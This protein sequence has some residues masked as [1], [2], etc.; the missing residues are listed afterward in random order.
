M[1]VAII[2]ETTITAGGGFNQS[3]NAILQFV[4]FREDGIDY[5]VFTSKIE[6]LDI[7]NELKIKSKTF[8][9]H[10][11]DRIIAGFSSNRLTQQILCCTNLI[12]P[13]ENKLIKEGYD[14]VYFLTPTA[15][16]AALR[17]LN[18]ILTIWDNCHRDFPEFPEVS[19]DTEFKRREFI[20]SYISQSFLTLVDSELLAER[21]SRRYGVDRARLLVMPFSPH[22]FL[23]SNTV[24]DTENVLRI[25]GLVR[26]YL[27]YPAQFWPH[28]NHIRII[29]A[30]RLLKDKGIIVTV[31]FTGTDMGCRQFVEGQVKKNG[32]NEQVHFLGFVPNNHITGLYNGCSAVIM[33]TYFGPTNIPPLEAWAM[34]KPLIYSKH[35]SSQVGDG[36]ILVDPDS[37]SE[38][39]DA[40]LK[41][42]SLE[43]LE[44][45]K[46][47]FIG[48][49]KLNELKLQRDLA[50]KHFLEYLC[51]FRQRL[52]NWK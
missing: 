9:P 16:V 39:A 30:L 4:K 41:L 32:L 10:F 8:K 26:G 13:F 42:Q 38:L 24:E 33:P 18:F 12:S 48:L 17:K 29:Q 7:L 35:L 50:E 11:F 23:N 1:R 14:I 34:R 52:S 3:L 31:V 43:V 5:C 49:N 44:K 19:I 6:N 47:I 51:R 46:L 45:N 2:I 20:C 27:F 28:K 15:R 40:I 25:Y 22:P 37:E 21:I 36:A